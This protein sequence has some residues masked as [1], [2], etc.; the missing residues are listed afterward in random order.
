[1]LA[2]ASSWVP[3]SSCMLDVADVRE[4]PSD[5]AVPDTSDDGVSSDTSDGDSSVYVLPPGCLNT[6]VVLATCDPRTNAGCFSGLGC[7]TTFYTQPRLAC[8]PNDGVQKGDPCNNATGPYCAPTLTCSGEPG[9]CSSFCC[10]SAECANGFCLPFD[11]NLGSLGFCSVVPTDSG[12][13]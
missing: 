4:A 7:D 6:D 9:V 12:P 8:L 11:P 5:A 3:F 2:A 13:G 1:M 10:T